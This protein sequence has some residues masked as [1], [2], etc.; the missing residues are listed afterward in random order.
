MEDLKS[1]EQSVR[2]QE[3]EEDTGLLVEVV[4]AAE[5]DERAASPAAPANDSNRTDP[6]T[7][8][9]ATTSN[10]NIDTCNDDDSGGKQVTPEP[11]LSADSETRLQ[12]VDSP[13]CS[14]A[15]AEKLSKANVAEA[16]CSPQPRH[17]SN[18]QRSSPVPMRSQ[19]PRTA[20]M[21][22]RRRRRKDLSLVPIKTD[23]RKSR[24]RP[25]SASS[26]P[27]T[28]PHGGRP[29]SPHFGTAKRNAY[30]KLSSSTAEPVP[31]TYATMADGRAPCPT[32]YSKL[33]NR[34]IEDPA[35]PAGPITAGRHQV[36]GHSIHAQRDL[37]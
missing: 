10:D 23:G 11:A 1:N 30:L 33:S 21:G 26:S 16:S 5:V 15:L 32:K 13:S 7:T 19:R 37:S 6:S 25:N 8:S 22:G 34:D 27:A 20:P 2:K 3:Q 36:F 29:L 18:N 28:S 14:V 4:E 24:S 12:Q 9:Y 17:E 31:S 35:T